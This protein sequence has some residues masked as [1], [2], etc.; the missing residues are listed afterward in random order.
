MMIEFGHNQHRYR[1]TVVG[2]VFTVDWLDDGAW[3]PDAVVPVATA[4]ALVALS[5]LLTD[6]AV[7]S[8]PYSK[9]F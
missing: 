9:A 5:P 2:D 8:N 3:V 1:I 4:E 6:A 7:G